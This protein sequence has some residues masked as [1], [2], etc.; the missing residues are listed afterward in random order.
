ME[1]FTIY[2]K[3]EPGQLAKVCDTL[4]RNGVNIESLAT[5]G[6]RKDGTIKMVTNDVVT[7]KKALE[8][9]KIPFETKEVLVVKIINRPGELAKI[10]KKIG[11]E[12]VNIESVYMFTDEKFALR[13]D[14]TRKTREILKEDLFE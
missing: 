11:L 5:E 8:K 3:N 13:V 4:Y 6:T 14:D 10:T 1:E 2:V 9:E 7:T 12:S